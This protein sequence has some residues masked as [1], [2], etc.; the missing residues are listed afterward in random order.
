ML[1]ALNYMR[2]YGNL[3]PLTFRELSYLIL[4][5]KDHLA[6]AKDVYFPGNHGIRQDI[7][8]AATAI[9]YPQLPD[10]DH[11][12]DLAGQRLNKAVDTFFTREGI[13][14]EHA[15]GYVQY[16]LRLMITIDRLDK[17]SE[18]FNPKRFLAQFDPSL[19]FLLASLAPNG[20]LPWIGSTGTST[21]IGPIKKFSE[22]R[23]GKTLDKMIREN[24]GKEFY[25]PHYN[26]FI[27]RA[28]SPEGLH[29]HFVSAQNL[30]A[31]KRHAD[32]LSFLLFNYGRNWITEGGHHS[33]ELSGMT[34]YLRSPYAH[35]GYILGH[36]YIPPH[37]K[38]QLQAYIENVS[39]DTNGATVV[40]GVS[41]RYPNDGRVVRKLR[42]GNRTGTLSVT[43]QLS[44]KLGARECFT[45]FL[46]LPADLDVAIID[47][48]IEAID[49]KRRMKMTVSVGSEAL[50]SI[51]SVRGKE[52]PIAGW[53]MSDGQF[54]PITRVDS[55][56]CGNGTVHYQFT[57]RTF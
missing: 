57:W 34:T 54:G 3:G 47:S 29:V 26:H 35:N 18:R 27:S 50:E 16:V 19:R 9:A 11:L 4:R 24:A 49:Q 46:N 48:K 51:T 42:V 28:A 15:P 53:G 55:R 32:A 52:K 41:E 17:A 8:L 22:Q 30:P 21:I 2:R 37:G 39:K 5:D 10:A 7:A 56:F 14:A 31:K 12:L 36:E 20:N 43:D 44:Q 25:F 45:G 6:Y 33:Y 13:W 23:L 40:T 1:T 38:P